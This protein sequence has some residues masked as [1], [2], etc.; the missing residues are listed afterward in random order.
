MAE[1][2]PIVDRARARGDQLALIDDQGSM[3]YAELLDASARAASRLLDA[4]DDLEGARVAFLTPPGADYV[5]AQWGTWRAGGIAVPLCTMHPAPELD[6]VIGDSGAE[7]IVAHP[8]YHAVLEP[9]A[10]ARG[11]RLLSTETLRDAEPRPLPTVP[12]DRGAMLIYTSGTTGKP[13]GALS[14]HATLSA[15][16]RSVVEAWEWCED[17]RILHVLPLHHLHGI[18]NLLCAAMW[19]GATCEFLPRFDPEHVWKRLA[20]S[21]GLTLFMAVPTIYAKLT[22]AFDRADTERQAAMSAGC[23]RLRLMVSGSAALPVPTL[24]RWRTI[25]GHT[26][27]ERYGMTEIG[28]GLGNPLHGERRPG[29]VGVPFPGVDVRLVDDAGSEVADG[30]SGHIEVRSPGVF[31]GYWNREEATREVFTDDGWFKTGDVAVR[32]DGVYRILGRQSVD[33]LKT[34]GY[35]VSALEIE[36]VLRTHPAIAEC[37]VVGVADPQWGQRVAAVV[38]LAPGQQLKLETLRSWGKEQ[39]A[40]YK[41][42]TLLRVVDALPRNPMGKVQKPAVSELFQ[43]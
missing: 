19:S 26:L 40:H 13:K 11:V 2:I 8:E 4:R 25:S 33:I 31:D 29:H 22:E 1:S 7:L 6:Y 17:D 36:A 10:R 27:L 9:L 20:D 21:E 12:G 28:M 34:G 43:G 42:P 37:A 5:V 32:E 15:Q 24:E 39:M 23:K 35:K 16:I 18:L 41:V 3:R 38:V 14:T 30:T